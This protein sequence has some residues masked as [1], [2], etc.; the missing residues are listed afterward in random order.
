MKVLVATEKPFA[1][2]AVDGIR[3][4]IAESGYELQLLEKYSSK[5]DLLGAVA[6]AD[7]V[8]IR[9]DV[10][11]AEVL[12][13]AKRLRIV[14]RAGAGYDNVDL[15]A[16][17]A[18]G[19][20]VENTPGQNSNAVAELVFGMA[21]MAVRNMYNGTS[22][23]EMKGKRLGLQAY[24]QVGRNVARIAKGV[25]MEVSAYDPYCP[26]D[27][28][29]ADGIKPVH[30]VEE[31]YAGNDFVSIHIPATPE[32]KKSIGFD[33][34]TKMPKGGVL[35]NTARKEVID[36]EGLDKALEARADLKYVAD[37]K[38]DSAEEL[39]AR[40][41]DRVFFTPKKMGAQT[42]EANIN[43][44]IA[45]ARQVVDYLRDGINKYQVNK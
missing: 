45:A 31:L 11:D 34:I 3:K 29:V 2:V 32:T 42:A 23:T 24:G 10:I 39:K 5:A 14:V 33:L 37:V 25:G 35:I 20:V 16:A 12:D 22:G 36:E 8:I 44:G 43:A 9:S 38:P 41:G 7:A 4:V 30:S 26:D 21:V 1:A 17:T 27:V 6:D 18:H 19:V 13:A 15:A 40:F 28:M